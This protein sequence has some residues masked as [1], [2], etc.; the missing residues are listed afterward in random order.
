MNSSDQGRNKNN[1]RQRKIAE[2]FEILDNSNKYEII[3]QKLES[4]LKI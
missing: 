4:L 1:N 2:F 3:I